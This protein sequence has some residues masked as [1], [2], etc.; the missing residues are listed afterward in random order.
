MF[1][2]NLKFIINIYIFL[3]FFLHSFLKLILLFY[4]NLMKLKFIFQNLKF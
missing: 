4:I 1:F 2:Y 3:I